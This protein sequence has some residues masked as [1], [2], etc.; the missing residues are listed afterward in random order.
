M[1][2]HLTRSFSIWSIHVEPTSV[3]PRDHIMKMTF[4]EGAEKHIVEAFGMTVESGYIVDPETGERE[5]YNGKDVHVDD[6]AMVEHGSDIFVDDSFD[7]LVEHV[8]RN[9]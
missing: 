7:S 9:R 3:T 6:L 8:E 1:E 5:Q 4:Q 2:V